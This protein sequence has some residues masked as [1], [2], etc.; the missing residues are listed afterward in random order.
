MGIEDRKEASQSGM[1]KLL[2]VIAVF[3]ILT[4]MMSSQ[5]IRISNLTSV[6]LYV[7][8]ILYVICTSMKLHL[9]KRNAE[10]QYKVILEVNHQ[11][12]WREFCLT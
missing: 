2:G 8:H 11:R 3:I 10:E 12:V 9:K 5:Y 1:R 4:F 7:F 6:P